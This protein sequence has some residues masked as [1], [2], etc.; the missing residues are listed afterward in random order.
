MTSDESWSNKLRTVG[1]IERPDHYYLNPGDECAFF[2]EYTARKGWRHST[3]NGIITNL[4][5]SVE[6][7]GTAEWQYKERAIAQ[8]AALIRANLAADVLPNITIVPA[9]PSRAPT[10]PLYDDRVERIARCIGAGIDVRCLLSTAQS[11]DAAHLSDDRP[12]PDALEQGLLWNQQEANRRAVGNIIIVLDDVLVTGAT[13]V[14]CSRVLKRAYPA[15]SVY[16]L[17]VARRVPE[18]TL[19][20]N[21]FDI[22]L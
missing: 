9:P 17:F 14:A 21:D 15:V 7:R 4:K 8:V 5:K 12:G 16:G 3:T 10:D 11:R 19:P 20:F 6:K 1:D 2:G 13:F 18:R 22:E